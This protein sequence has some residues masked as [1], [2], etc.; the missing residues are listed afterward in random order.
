MTIKS[1]KI[2]K[3]L[4]RC[5]HV[6]TKTITVEYLEIFLKK[7]S[8]CGRFLNHCIWRILLDGILKYV[9]EKK[10]LLSPYGLSAGIYWRVHDDRCITPAFILRRPPSFK[11]LSLNTFFLFSVLV[12]FAP[13]VF[14]SV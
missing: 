7:E 2:V 1:G 6:M 13:L 14:T 9:V 11:L 10:N 3:R 12:Y 4:L 5:N 8:N